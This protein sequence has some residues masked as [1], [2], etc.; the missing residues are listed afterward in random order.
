MTPAALARLHAEAFTT[1]RPWSEVEF[2]S[3]LSGTG[4]FLVAE[5]Q[6]FA[7]GRAIAGEAELLTIAVADQARRG[8]IGRR[9]LTAFLKEAAERGSATVFL[10]VAADNAPAIAL[11]RAAGFAQTGRRR[12]YYAGP[13]G[14]RIDALVLS[15][16]M[17]GPAPEI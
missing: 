3:L 14:H 11:Y 8:G 2:A 10:E 7:L 16:A 9:L 17:T 4:S 13:G 6:G 5:P 15:R 1:P 12:G